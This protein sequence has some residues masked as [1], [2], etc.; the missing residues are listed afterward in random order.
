M[1]KPF[2]RELPSHDVS[3]AAKMG[4]EDLRNGKL[5]AAAAPSFDV[6]LTVDKNMKLEQNLATLPIAVIV[7]DAIRNTPEELKAF[8]P[9]VESALRS[10]RLGQ[11]I[12]IDAFGQVV[13]LA[14]GR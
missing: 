4:W 5:L 11:M 2:R 14:P 1:P 9:F 13:I 3:T 10:L 7:L 6:L 8:A 12:E